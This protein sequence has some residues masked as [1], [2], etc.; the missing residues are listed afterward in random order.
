MVA[1]VHFYISIK[2]ILGLQYYFFE[3][4]FQY[5]SFGFAISS[6]HIFCASDFN[7]Y[8]SYSPFHSQE[9]SDDLA[10]AQVFIDFT[11]RRSELNTFS[12]PHKKAEFSL[13]RSQ[14]KS[15]WCIFTHREKIGFMSGSGWIQLEIPQVKGNYCW[16]MFWFQL[17]I[18]GDKVPGNVG[19]P[20]KSML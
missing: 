15:C 14:K 17:P 3:F 13:E 6:K 2:L 1:S 11:R 19:T 7:S 18:H 16:N 20:L 8:I 12:N 4:F 5:L 10:S 9:F